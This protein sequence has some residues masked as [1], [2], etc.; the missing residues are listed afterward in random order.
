MGERGHEGGGREESH[1]IQVVTVVEQEVEK[2]Y[3]PHHGGAGGDGKSEAGSER[4]LVNGHRRAGEY[5]HA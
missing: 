5:K 2:G 1:G 4:E 3:V